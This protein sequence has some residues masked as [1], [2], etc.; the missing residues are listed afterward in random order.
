ME[1]QE[2]DSIQAFD[3]LY[4]TNQIQILKI[5]LP[6]CAPDIQ[7]NLAVMIRFL[8]L[9]YTIFFVRSHPEAFRSPPLPLS[10]GELC[11][12]IRGYCPPALRALLDQFQSIQNAMQMYEEMKQMMELFGDIAPGPEGQSEES[13]TSMDDTSMDDTSMDDTSMDGAFK[14]GTPMG[15]SP[16]DPLNM[17]M[18]MLSP[19]QKEMFQMF[20]SEFQT[21]AAEKKPPEK[22]N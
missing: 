13:G 8:E 2:Q 11:E 15:D 18:G 20:Q 16:M 12:K 6:Y 1:K 9:Q 3:T 10:F 19:S 14:N 17:L 21:E 22:E 7:R 4:T 5:L